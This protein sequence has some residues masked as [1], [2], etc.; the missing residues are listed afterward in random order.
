MRHDKGGRLWFDVS[1]APLGDI[2]VGAELRLYKL[3][4]NDSEKYTVTIYRVLLDVNGWENGFVWLELR[5]F[6]RSRCIHVLP[7]LR[8]EKELEYVHSINTTSHYQ[9]WLVFNVTAP[10]M[11][12]TAFQSSNRGLYVSVHRHSKPGN[13][14]HTWPVILIETFHIV[15]LSISAHEIHPELTRIITTVDEETENQQPF[16]VAFFQYGPNNTKLKRRR[17]RE[18]PTT[19]KRR[20]KS[21]IDVSH[22]TNPFSSSYHQQ[23]WA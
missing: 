23:L 1:D 15:I 22:S 12:W 4:S 5:F 8:R 7:K 17:I 20:K 19:N 16:M 3:R 6:R 18:A 10:F 2:I 11:A 21:E 9:G 13:L 14:R